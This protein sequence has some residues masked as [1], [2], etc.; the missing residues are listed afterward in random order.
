[1]IMDHGTPQHCSFCRRPQG[2]VHRLIS[3]P[4]GVFICHECVDLCREILE[5]EEL[6]FPG[7]GELSHD[8]PSPQQI[9]EHLNGYVVGQE[10]AKRV[11]SVAVYNHYKRIKAH[12][13]YDDV[14]IDKSNILVVG[15]TGVGKTL[16]AQ[17]LA[18]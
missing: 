14:E 4:D 8:V 6:S 16:M 1:M 7:D 13:Q 17:T 11:L 15:P 12:G 3:G 9:Y 5:E 2:E 18:R 10:R